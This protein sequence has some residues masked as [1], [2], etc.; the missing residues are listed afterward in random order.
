MLEYNVMLGC[1]KEEIRAAS[2]EK[3]SIA[4]LNKS[5]KVVGGY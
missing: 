5:T 2:V 3:T 4:K 1:K